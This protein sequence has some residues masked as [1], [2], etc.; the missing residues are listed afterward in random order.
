MVVIDLCGTLM[1]SIQQQAAAAQAFS[2]DA[3]AKAL[4]PSSL[5]KV[6]SATVIPFLP[7][8]LIKCFLA[9]VIAVALNKIPGFQEHPKTGNGQPSLSHT[10]HPA[11]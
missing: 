10:E 11:Q 7:G 8:D 5:V 6:L 4:A 1:F 3:L 9:A 2:L